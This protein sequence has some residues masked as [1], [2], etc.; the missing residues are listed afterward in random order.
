MYFSFQNRLDYERKA[1]IY[2]NLITYKNKLSDLYSSN[3]ESML[4]FA[5]EQV[6]D[7]HISDHLAIIYEDV[8][9]IDFIK[10]NMANNL[11]SLIFSR[12]V[13]TDNKS[14]KNL[15]VI[16]DEFVD[17]FVYPVI[18]G[19]AYPRLYSRN[20]SLFFEDDSGR[21]TYVDKD[22]AK[23]IINENNYVH[24][25]KRYV[26]GNLP[27]FLYL[28]EGKRQY[29]TVDEENADFCRDLVE[30]ESI[31]PRLKS[32]I[33]MLLLH[34]YFDTDRISTL[35]EFLLDRKSVV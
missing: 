4:V 32:E 35:D 26:T 27:F 13:T 15:V 17:E 14:Y 10:P 12:L 25:I 2:A 6:M 1:F 23:R 8:L 33:R 30:S 28:C 9:T 18:N 34:F 16:Y 31:S 5:I 3:R 29:I 22:Q 7:K 20:V 19:K 21:R 11:S 24:A